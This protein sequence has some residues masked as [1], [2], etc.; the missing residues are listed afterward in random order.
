MKPGRDR[1]RAGSG[2]GGTGDGNVSRS[3][4]RV[5]AGARA[6]S[7]ARSPERGSATVWVAVSVT[8]LCVVFAAVL[9]LGQVV[10]ARHRAGAAADL[11]ALAAADNAPRGPVPACA[12]AAGVAREQ[13]A[14]MVR[15][16]VVGAL[17]EVTVRARVGPY[18]PKVRSRAGPPETLGPAEPPAPPAPLPEEVP[19][20]AE[21]P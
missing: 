17:A 12:E 20:P 2:A 9:A 19:A 3:G 13:G 8:V 1:L 7:R 16:A 11:A 14:E 21:P 15:C 10:V 18:G 6:G 5:A 4:G